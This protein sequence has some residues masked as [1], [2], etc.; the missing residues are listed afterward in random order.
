[1]KLTFVIALSAFFVSSTYAQSITTGAI[2]SSTICAGDS[3]SVSYSATGTFTGKNNFTAELSDATGSFSPSFL[4]IGSVKSLTSGNIVAS[5]PTNQPAGSHYRIRVIS[6]NPYVVGSDNGNDLT[7]GAQPV[8]SF[9]INRSSVL[10][11]D[12]VIF[13][14]MPG[15]ATYSWAFGDGAIP[16]FFIGQNP[17]AVFYSTPGFKAISLT[18]S[19]ASGCTNSYTMAPNSDDTMFYGSYNGDALEVLSCNPTIPH[20][21]LVDSV[22]RDFGTGYGPIWVDPGTTFI[23]ET[24]SFVVFAEAG[25]SVQLPGTGNLTVYLKDGSSYTGGAT[26]SHRLIYGPGAGLN[27]LRYE[28]LFPCSSLSFDYSVAPP[29]KIEFAPASVAVPSSMQ[30]IQTYPNPASEMLFV[31][32]GATPTSVK[33]LNVLGDEVMNVGGALTSRLQIN[34]SSFPAGTYM[35]VIHFGSQQVTRKVVIGR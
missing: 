2:G 6:S 13:T 26:G 1:M 24:G 33:L 35:L 18:V 5:I 29:N 23:A 20:N 7:L 3:I 14:A 9:R 12:S 21:A 8:A 22:T 32:M 17:P 16:S 4:N 34:V 15:A 28:T 27:S 19:S 31:Q 30:D 10:E 25:S 11:G